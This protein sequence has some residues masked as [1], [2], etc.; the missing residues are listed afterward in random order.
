MYPNLLLVPRMST[1]SKI[2][3]L[4][5]YHVRIIVYVMVKF[6]TS[7][8][9]DDHCRVILEGRPGD[10]GSDYINASFIDVSYNILQLFICIIVLYMPRATIRR[11][12]ILSLKA[13]YRTPV[14]T[15]GEW[16]GKRRLLRL[17]CSPN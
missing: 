7:F 3:W 15:S 4:M 1:N 16:Y 17:L 8:M 12:L 2:V 5:F 9:I 10:E 6:L 11:Q 14:V 13:H